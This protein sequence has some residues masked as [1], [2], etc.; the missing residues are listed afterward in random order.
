VANFDV[1]PYETRQTISHLGSGN[2]VHRWAPT[3]SATESVS[4]LN[5]AQLEP[6]FARV[7]IELGDW[8]PVND[9]TDPLQTSPAAFVD[10]GYNH[11]AF[12]L[13]QRLRADGVELIATVWHVPDW[14][15]E[16][17][18]VASP[19]VINRATYPEAIES[20]A[21]W[22]SH[23]KEV[24][25]VDVT[26]VSF[27]EAS[28]GIDGLLSPDDYVQMIKDGNL[29]QTLPTVTTQNGSVTFAL[30]GS[31]VGYLVENVEL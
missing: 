15:A 18:E 20:I 29:D 13:M 30:P 23:A 26:Y 24:Y 8:E 5:L 4:E 9:N 7:S 19:R 3:T 6:R 31:S 2:F 1:Y 10:D 14:M 11:A 16:N 12:E 21:A 25:G 17:P 28:L 27:N 22:L